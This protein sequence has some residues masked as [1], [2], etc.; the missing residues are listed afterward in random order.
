MGIYRDV[1]KYP[2]LQRN[3]GILTMEEEIP[4]DSLGPHRK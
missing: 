2:V 1:G 3:T 4:E